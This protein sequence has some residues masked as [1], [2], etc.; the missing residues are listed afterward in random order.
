MRRPGLALW[1]RILGVVMVVGGLIVTSWG[2]YHYRQATAPPELAPRRPVPAAT[3]TGVTT[4]APPRAIDIPV[5]GLHADIEEQSPAVDG[6]Y[7]PPSSDKVAWIADR[8]QPGSPATDTVYLL[9]HSTLHGHAVFSDLVDPAAGT[10]RLKAGDEIVVETANGS[11]VYEVMRSDVVARADLANDAEMWAAKPG[12]LVLVT[13][14]YDQQRRSIASNV[15]V[16]AR[17]DPASSNTSAS[18][19]GEHTS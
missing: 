3:A 11:V 18:G 2:W 12:R 8:G 13:C 6:V 16:Y 7:T 4:P 5:L 19:T 9:G 1:A 14:L 10:S 15:V 17:L